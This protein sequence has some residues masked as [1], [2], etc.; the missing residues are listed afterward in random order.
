VVM[1]TD[2]NNPAWSKMWDPGRNAAVTDGSHYISMIWL[3]GEDFGNERTGN[4][5]VS[6]TPGGWKYDPTF[7]DKYIDGESYVFTIERVGDSYALSVSGN[8]YYGGRR[9]YSATRRWRD[10][11]VTWHYNRMPDE[12]APAQWNQ[13][14]SYGGQP[15]QTWPEGSS[16]PD[17]FFFGDPHI[18]YYEGS[19]EYDDLK[20]YVR[21]STA[22]AAA[23][24]S[25]TCGHRLQR[26]V[27]MADGMPR[28]S[29]P[30]RS[31]AGTV[32]FYS[33]DGSVRGRDAPSSRNR[34]SIGP[35]R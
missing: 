27:E 1:D 2:N 18:N 20:L 23:A 10:D 26:T 22:V 21:P 15:Y 34:S 35:H 31:R 32:L 29:V 28:V 33:V 14:R 19:A 11:P 16:Y 9:T 3:N 25:R 12:Y 24:M 6:Y 8:F 13:T 30:R 4:Q 17:Y 5:F 7:V